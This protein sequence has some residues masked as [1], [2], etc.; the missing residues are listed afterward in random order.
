M[1]VANLASHLQRFFAERL[2]GQ[3]G[4]SPHTVASYRDTFRLLLVFASQHR[5]CQPCQLRVVD[6]DA[7]LV[8]SFLRHLEQDRGNG[9]RSRNTRLSAIHAFFRMVTVQEPEL[10]LHCQQVL[11]VPFKRFDRGPVEFL[12]PEESRALLNAPDTTTWRG[13]RDRMLLQLALQTGLRSAE[14]IALRRQDVE[15]D[16]GAHVRCLGK[17][18]KARCTP[19]RSEVTKELARWLA[20]QPSDPTTPVFPTASGGSMS[21]DALQSLVA[22]H[23]RIASGQCP[24]LRQ[25]RVTPHTLRHTTAMDLLRNGV[26]IAVI[27]LWLGHESIVS[28]QSYLHADMA[29]KEKA[30]SQGNQD[31]VPVKRYRPPDQLL[32]FLEGL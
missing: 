17:G 27:A 19:L 23:V 5:R 20:D 8:G 10:A 26:D 9:A 6:L 13:R 14:L 12:S 29:L 18:R 31:G 11:A 24:S 3:L 7:R 2:V 32:A 1:I 30:L 22:R 21:A 15:L 28:T 25:K 4:A 16:T